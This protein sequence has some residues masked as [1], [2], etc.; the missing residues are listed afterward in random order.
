MRIFQDH[1]AAPCRDAGD[2][3]AHDKVRPVR[4]QPDNKTPCDND[5]EIGGEVV[6]AESI[7]CP[8]VDVRIAEPREQPD[9]YRLD[10]CRYQGH[11][12]HDLAKGV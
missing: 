6:P 11:D 3:H 12:D 1:V 10:G 9:A 2:D 5:S 8:D 7:G 4:S